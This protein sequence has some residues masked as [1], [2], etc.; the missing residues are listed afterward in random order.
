MIVW[1][2]LV[3]LGT[4]LLVALRRL[5][6]GRLRPRWSWRHETLFALLRSLTRRTARRGPLA[7]QAQLA[8]VRAPGS[9]R[10]RRV[11][12]ERLAPGGVPAVCHT[13]READPAELP[14][15]L[16]LHG[17]GYVCCSLE[18]HQDLMIRLALAAPAR[19]LGLDYRLAPQHP[20][21]AAVEDALAA[22]RALVAGGEDPR[23]I[24]IAGD[25]AGGGLTLALLLSLRDAGDPLPAG[26]ALLSPWVEPSAGDPS[27]TANARFD[28]VGLGDALVELG[29]AYAGGAGLENPLIS[30]GLAELA[31]LP[32]LLVHAGGA[33][34]LLDQIER[35]V[36]R[37]R[38]AG[39]VVELEVWEDMVHVFQ[40]FAV[41]VPEG[42]EAIVKIGAFVTAR[43]AEAA[44][45]KELAS[46]G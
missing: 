16:Y 10:R 18:T 21:P 7:L 37:A 42:V 5:F 32:P 46:A 24:V 12:L 14:L 17:G 44:S 1:L 20:F 2:A 3:F 23:R 29:R 39:V 41:A 11:S 30:V 19:V 38:A 45:Q 34:V 6:R 35:L 27:L 28:Y 26:A 31:G 15:I 43:T 33:E 22:Y 13:P 4:G 25:S 8:R 40:A 36:A 9:P